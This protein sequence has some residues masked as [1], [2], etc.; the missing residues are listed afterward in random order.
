MRRIGVPISGW[1]ALAKKGTVAGAR[2]AGRSA[3]AGGG[4]ARREVDAMGGGS[5]VEVLDGAGLEVGGSIAPRL[6]FA[7]GEEGRGLAHTRRGVLASAEGFAGWTGF[8]P[9]IASECM[10]THAGA[11]TVVPRRHAQL[12]TLHRGCSLVHL[13]VLCA[14]AGADRLART[15]LPSWR[16]FDCLSRCTMQRLGP[17]RVRF[18]QST[19]H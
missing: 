9:A 3:G 18:S 14:P 19:P 16:A 5:T 7:A 13:P 6:S 11:T 17:T 1:A 12:A 10:R 4:G 15:L 2:V 8:G